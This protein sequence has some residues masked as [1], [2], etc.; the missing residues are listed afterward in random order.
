MGLGSF[1]HQKGN[2]IYIA[3]KLIPW[4]TKNPC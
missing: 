3:V 1:W 4:E 2:K